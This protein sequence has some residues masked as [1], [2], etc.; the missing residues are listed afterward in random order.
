MRRRQR[1][2]AREDMHLA[3]VTKGDREIAERSGLA[4]QL[5]VSVCQPLPCLRHPRGGVPRRSPPHIQRS[6]SVCDV[7]LNCALCLAQNRHGGGITVAEKRNQAV[8][9]QVQ[10]AGPWRSWCGYSQPLRSRASLRPVR[11]AARRRWPPSVPPGTSRGPAQD[12]PPEAARRLRAATLRRRRHASRG[13]KSRPRSKPAL[14]CSSS[15]RTPDSAVA[16]KR[17]A[18]SSAPACSFAWAAARARPDLRDSSGVSSVARSR[19]AAAAAKPPRACARAA[20]SSS[21]AATSSSGVEAACARCQARRSGSSSGSVASAR[22]R[23]ISRRS[24]RPA[25]R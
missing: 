20:D 22:A 10:R 17:R 15:L 12:R 23:W 13:T 25:A 18:S 9:Q 5:K 24:L 6:C 19:N 2:L 1:Q 7:A 16:T 21:S 14:A 4:D 3:A 11:P 8:E